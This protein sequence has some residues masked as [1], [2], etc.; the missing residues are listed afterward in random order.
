MQFKINMWENV[1]HKCKESNSMYCCSHHINYSKLPS[2]QPKAGLLALHGCWSRPKSQEASS[3]SLLSLIVPPTFLPRVSPEAMLPPHS[4]VGESSPPPGMAGLETGTHV[5]LLSETS[6]ELPPWIPTYL[7]CPST[8]V[9]MTLSS[10]WQSP[11]HGTGMV[12]G[13]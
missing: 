1:L 13:K 5:A 2:G 11:S 7:F 10:Q 12:Q 6:L 4:T 8:M 3:D 9:L